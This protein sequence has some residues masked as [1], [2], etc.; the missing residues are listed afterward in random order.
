MLGKDQEEVKLFKKKE[1]KTC[2]DLSSYE[3]HFKSETFLQV[4]LAMRRNNSMS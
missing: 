1:P 2:E 3:G 4:E